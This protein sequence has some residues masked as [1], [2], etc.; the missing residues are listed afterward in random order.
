MICSLVW[1][2]EIRAC[3]KQVQAAILLGDVSRVVA[4]QLLHIATC[5]GRACGLNAAAMYVEDRFRCALFLQTVHHCKI[6]SS[7]GGMSF[8][9]LLPNL[10]RRPR[11]Q[12]SKKQE[13][14]SR[15]KPPNARLSSI[16]KVSFLGID[17]VLVSDCHPKPNSQPAVVADDF[18]CGARS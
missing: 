6:S 17:V 4:R 14:E 3:S 13:G 15:S 1:M 7:G 18:F 10:A 11:V 16:R 12:A 9:H 8:R 5:S 2:A